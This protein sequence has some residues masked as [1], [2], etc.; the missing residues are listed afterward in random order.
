MVEP[1]YLFSLG[2]VPEDYDQPDA[3]SSFFV[4]WFVHEFVDDPEDPER[5]A[6]APDEPLAVVHLRCHGE[7]LSTTEHRRSS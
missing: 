1:S 4:P 7:R 6:D 5:V 2:R 3:L